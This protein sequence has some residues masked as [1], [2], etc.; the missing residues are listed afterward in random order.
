MS[1][2]VLKDQIITNI[3]ITKAFA[4][5]FKNTDS[6]IGKFEFGCLQHEDYRPTI[7]ERKTDFN[8][9]GFGSLDFETGMYQYNLNSTILWNTKCKCGNTGVVGF[10]L[11]Y[12]TKYWEGIKQKLQQEVLS[13]KNMKE[14][15]YL[16]EE[17]EISF[18]HFTP[19]RKKEIKSKNDA[20]FR[21]WYENTKL[22]DYFEN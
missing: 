17:S 11:K 7:V 9:H 22:D 20:P 16:A 2:D 19:Y 3:E 15:L 21:S 8:I 6:L 1:K 10:I 13:E 5:Y 18:V 4:N 14:K 12:N